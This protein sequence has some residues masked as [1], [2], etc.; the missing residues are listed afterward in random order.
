MTGYPKIGLR[1]KTGMISDK[2]AKARN[3]QNVDFR[4][5]EDPKEV[6]PEHSRATGLGIEEMA[7]EIPIDQQHDLRSRQRRDRNQNHACLHKVEPRQQGH[8]AEFHARAS[9]AK[10]GGNNV[11]GRSN[12]S[13]PGDQQRESPIVGT[14]P[15]R[16]GSRAQWRVRPPADVGCVSCAVQ[17]ASSEKAEIKK[18]CHPETIARS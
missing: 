1:E 17:A 3:D 15:R 16:E 11:D 18:K 5:S 8:A 10:N 7:S 6:H 9:H 14:M 4:M 12:A 2:K 13:K